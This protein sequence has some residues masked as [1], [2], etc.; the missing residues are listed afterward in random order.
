[1][2]IIFFM[3]MWF[4]T[5]VQAQ[6]F[7][8]TGTQEQAEKPT[9]PTVKKAKLSLEEEE[10]IEVK[11]PYQS[12]NRAMFNFNDK[13]YFHVLKPIAK[14]YDFLVPQA[15]QKSVRKFFVNLRMPIRFF[16]CVFQAKITG[17][18][19]EMVRFMINSSIGIGGFFDP[20]TSYFHL[21]R[22]NEDFGQT[23][24]YHGAKEGFYI[25][26][27]FFGPSTLRD[28]FGFIGD[29]ALN[30]L[31]YVSIFVEPSGVGTGVGALNYVNEVAL[32]VGDN[33]ESIKKSA[34]D[35]YIAIQ[36]AYVQNRA[37]RIKE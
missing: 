35:P 19:T 21:A 36:D 10:P 6:N 20:A 22:Y 13:L 1:M 14:G 9:A 5:P 12:F 4:K 33:Y 26:W 2:V 3:I 28:T 7:A 16:N 8:G 31:T 23:L 34:V 30:P 25:V 18:D 11:D 24:G 37:K 27:P 32:D 15:A 17:A 29:A